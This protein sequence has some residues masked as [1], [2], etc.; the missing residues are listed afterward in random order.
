[1][2]PTHSREHREVRGD[3]PDEPEADY[4]VEPDGSEPGERQPDTDEEDG[5]VSRVE[6][7]ADHAPDH[8]GEVTRHPANLLG[9]AR[10]RIRHAFV[11]VLHP[12]KVVIGEVACG[13]VVCQPLPPDER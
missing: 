5:A 13:Y 12:V 1:M 10:L 11:D 7:W 6:E 8:L 3:A 4:A 2:C 9:D